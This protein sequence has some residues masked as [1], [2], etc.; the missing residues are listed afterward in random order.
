MCNILHCWWLY[1]YD[2]CY[3]FYYCTLILSA[4]IDINL[5][6]SGSSN[7]MLNFGQS[8]Q[9][10]TSCCYIWYCFVWLNIVCFSVKVHWWAFQLYQSNS[11][12][13]YEPTGIIFKNLRDTESTETY[14]FWF[15]CS[16]AAWLKIQW[17]SLLLV[18]L[19]QSSCMK[20]GPPVSALKWG[21]NPWQQLFLLDKRLSVHTRLQKYTRSLVAVLQ[22]GCQRCLSSCCI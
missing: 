20:T 2:L 14:C 21:S 5:D 17:F 19:K 22:I 16:T 3:T 6:H 18:V 11:S 1:V 9:F 13:D 8:P 12:A 10:H 7:L 15:C 4:V